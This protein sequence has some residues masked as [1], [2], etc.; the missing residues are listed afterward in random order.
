[1][2]RAGLAALAAAIAAA[3]GGTALQTS[4]STVG[5]SGPTLRIGQATQDGSTKAAP[6]RS[7]PT[8]NA[9]VAKHA[10]RFRPR[11]F[12]FRSGNWR[13]IRTT[14]GAVAVFR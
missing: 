1:M 14:R 5:V 2:R 7:A 3:A 4:T 6:T 8:Q 13:V 12:R 11:R 9:I 10:R